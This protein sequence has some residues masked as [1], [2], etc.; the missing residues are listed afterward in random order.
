MLLLLEV[1]AASG[2]GENPDTGGGIAIIVG[3][4]IALAIVFALI[5]TFVVRRTRGERTRH[6]H[7]RPGPGRS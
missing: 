4:V 7:H 5:A 6:G 3:S 2:T 1:F